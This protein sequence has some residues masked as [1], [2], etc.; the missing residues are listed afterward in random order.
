MTPIRLLAIDIDGTLLDSKWNLPEGNRRAL[1]EAYRRGVQI[2]F[3]TGRRY[4]ITYPITCTFDFPH[5]VITTAGAVARSHSSEHIFAHNLEP[6][7]VSEFISHIQR[8]RPFT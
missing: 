6:E 2:V 7:L 5:Y 8:F 4:H 1:V 3:V